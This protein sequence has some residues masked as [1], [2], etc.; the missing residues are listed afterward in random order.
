MADTQKT[1]V[2][3]HEPN[4]TW[5][6]EA[7][8]NISNLPFYFDFYI[9]IELTVSRFELLPLLSFDNYRLIYSFAEYINGIPLYLTCVSG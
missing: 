2:A 1:A 3:S 7:I 6:S 9:I 4:G 5:H 8:L